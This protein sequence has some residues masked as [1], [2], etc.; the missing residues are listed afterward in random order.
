MGQAQ[1]QMQLIESAG[2]KNIKH[3]H[4]LCYSLPLIHNIHTERTQPFNIN[5]INQTLCASQCGLK[6][7]CVKKDNPYQ[8]CKLIG[9]R[10]LS[11]F[12]V[13]LCKRLSS[14]IST[15][16]R[17][18]FLINMIKL[19]LWTDL[20]RIGIGLDWYEFW[21]FECDSELH[22]IRFETF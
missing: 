10:C 13:N 7:S 15:L 12:N 6:G 18:H 19:W 5:W 11:C 16:C 9:S 2:H 1:L 20:E 22:R 21:T 14:L 4:T 8:L 3:P 17:L